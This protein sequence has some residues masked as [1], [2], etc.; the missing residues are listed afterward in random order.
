M[1]KS[2]IQA[3][4]CQFSPLLSNNTVSYSDS[5]YFEKFQVLFTYKCNLNK[6]F[7]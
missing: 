6:R 5:I 1:G 7:V 2:E 4:N 3:I